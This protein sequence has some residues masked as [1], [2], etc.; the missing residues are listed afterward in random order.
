MEM[1]PEQ[2]IDSAAESIGSQTEEGYEKLL[3][4]FE[5]KQPIVLAYIFSDNLNLLTGEERNLLLYL[6]LVTRKA[7]MK[8][9][10]Y[11]PKSPTEDKLAEAED[12]NWSKIVDSNTKDFRER[13]NPFF[14]RTP[15]EDLLA[16]YEDILMDEEEESITKAGREYIFV[17]AKSIM[18]VWCASS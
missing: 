17:A 5:K 4:E 13:L 10:R 9:N 18:D 1:I 12:K 8:S 11:D 3:V 14:E 2:I 16:F 15:Q 6:A 7:Y